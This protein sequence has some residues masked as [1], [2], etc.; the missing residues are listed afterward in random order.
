MVIDI[1]IFEFS[2][3]VLCF[4]AFYQCQKFAE[5]LGCLFTIGLVI[6]ISICATSLCT[7]LHQRT[8]CPQIVLSQITESHNF[9]SAQVVFA[10]CIGPGSCLVPIYWLHIGGLAEVYCGT[11]C[12]LFICKTWQS[13]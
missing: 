3:C 12:T 7:V 2:Q 11:V 5:S 4:A 6:I 9:I 13:K 8:S 10:F 1:F